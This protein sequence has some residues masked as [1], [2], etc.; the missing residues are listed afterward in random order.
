MSIK[1][2]APARVV[3]SVKRDRKGTHRNRQTWETLVNER[4]NGEQPILSPEAS[5]KAAKRLYRA[6]LGKPFTGTVELTSGRRYTWVRRGVLYVNPDMRQLHARGLRAIIHDLSHYAHSRLHPA[7]APH[8]KRQAALEGRL[9][10]YALRAGLADLDKPKAKPEPVEPA[11]AAPA[12][13]VAVKAKPDR[14][15]VR[16]SRMVKR[17][18]KWAAELERAK[19]LYAK[20]EAEVRTYERRHGARLSAE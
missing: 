10:T 19:R 17:R 2:N 7:D 6:A 12:E 16:Y 20:A 15:A 5:I 13:P 1:T 4:W 8:S 3:R 11:P 9:V 18:D 14:V